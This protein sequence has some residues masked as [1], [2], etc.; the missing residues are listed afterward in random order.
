MGIEHNSVWKKTIYNE[1]KSGTRETCLGIT[2]LFH[3]KLL[4]SDRFFCVSIVMIKESLRP[5]SE[6]QSLFTRNCWLQTG[7]FSLLLRMASDED[8]V[9]SGGFGEKYRHSDFLYSRND[10][11]KIVDLHFLKKQHVEKYPMIYLFKFDY[12]NV[13]LDDNF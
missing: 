7:C 1:S 6:S 9:V 8:Q 12:R 13:K 11:Y 3:K 10:Q 2:I 4:A 5:V